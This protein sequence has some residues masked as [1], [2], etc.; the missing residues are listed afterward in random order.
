MASVS[1][2]TSRWVARRGTFSVLARKHEIASASSSSSSAA[3]ECLA[4]LCGLC[5]TEFLGGPAGKLTVVEISNDTM[6]YEALV[7][8]WYHEREREMRL[9]G[10]LVPSSG[11]A[12]V[13]ATSPE[14]LNLKVC[15]LASGVDDADDDAEL[16]VDVDV[17][18]DAIEADEQQRQ[19]RESRQRSDCRHCS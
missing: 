6:R 12:S 16:E 18:V 4:R 13:G 11:A 7:S 8:A 1:I 9:V 10:W 19:V 14:Y 2:T 3:C 15:G 17:D 5:S